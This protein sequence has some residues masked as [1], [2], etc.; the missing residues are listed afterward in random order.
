MSRRWIHVARSYRFIS[1]ATGLLL[2][3]AGALKLSDLSARLP[4]DPAA[5][6]PA[7]ASMIELQGPKY[8]PVAER[9]VGAVLGGA[10]VLFGVWLLLGLLPRWT[11]VLALGVV[12]VLLN[13]AVVQGARGAESCGCFG[14]VKTSPWVAIGIDVAVLVA[15][16]LSHRPT[17]PVGRL[18]L[19]GAVLLVAVAAVV[20]AVVGITRAKAVGGTAGTGVTPPAVDH[21]TLIDEILRGIE[22]NQSGYKSFRMT[23]ETVYRD[24]KAT[25]IERY[26]IRLPDGGTNSTELRP[27]TRWQKTY[28]ITP[29]AVRCDVTCD[30]GPPTLEVATA[31]RYLYYI[32]QHKRAW[33]RKPE[34]HGGKDQSSLETTTWGF[35]L[36]TSMPVA[37]PRAWFASYSVVSA[38]RVG[39]AQ[40][41]IE[42]ELKTGPQIRLPQQLKMF[43]SQA[44]S[45][46]PLSMVIRLQEKWLSEKVEGTYRKMPGRDVWVPAVV[47]MTQWLGAAVTEETDTRVIA[48][49]TV[50]AKPPEAIDIPFPAGTFDPPLPAGVMVSDSI[51][52]GETVTTRKPVANVFTLPEQVVVPPP[53]PRPTPPLPV[54]PL[55][56]VNMV[57]LAAVVGMWRR[58]SS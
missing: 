14:R 35:S 58:A 26:S 56:A 42:V 7:E 48:R 19:R 50:T 20:G 5:L 38:A 33:L 17:T 53:A 12:V 13:V 43:F 8:A 34:V 10:E 9:R 30:V 21:Q 32:P 15:L 47:Q 39:G 24:L 41:G 55:A 36:C 1:I 3:T 37:N 28:C 44:H 16:L 40:P 2:V 49:M 54:V 25:K 31:E 4:Y 27:E 46:L 51:K 11:R 45:Y 22:A 57:V 52:T 18:W 6:T 29:E 23:A